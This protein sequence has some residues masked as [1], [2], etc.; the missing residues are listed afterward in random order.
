MDDLESDNFIGGGGAG[1]GLEIFIHDI[2]YY[3]QTYLELTGS[4]N[5]DDLLAEINSNLD[6]IDNL[7]FAGVAAVSTQKLGGGEIFIGVNNAV[8][9]TKKWLTNLEQANLK[10]AIENVLDS[11][12]GLT[13]NQV[14]IVSAKNDLQSS[15]AY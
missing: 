14:Q 13:Y 10:S 8:Y 6:V 15:D 11:I 2:T 5:V 4:N 1:D 9:Q 7:E 3:G 12:N